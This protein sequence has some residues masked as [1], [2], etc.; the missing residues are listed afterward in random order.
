MN[1]AQRTAWLFV[2]T[3]SLGLVLSGVAVVALYLVAGM[4]KAVAGIGFVGIAGLGGLAPAIFK[5]DRGKV[6][7]DE[8]DRAIQQ[9]AALGG[10]LTAF[11]FVGL[12]CM[13]PFFVLGPDRTIE[14]KWLPMMF[15]GAGI[16]HY[17]VH[18]LVTLEQYGWRAKEN[19]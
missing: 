1:R 14:V 6:A 11:L 3:T 2:I 8:R 7:F 9:K 19:E 4:P 5:K 13:I 17:F 10:F 16:C 12:G 15:M 18:S